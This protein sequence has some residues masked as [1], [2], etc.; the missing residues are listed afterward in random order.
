MK[1]GLE[2]ESYHLF[3]QQGGGWIFSTS[4]LKPVNW[5]WMGLK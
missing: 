2:T 1:L 5:G 4:L 3:F